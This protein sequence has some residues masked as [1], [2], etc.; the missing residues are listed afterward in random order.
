MT[1]PAR[2]YVGCVTNFDHGD[3]RLTIWRSDTGYFRL[4]EFGIFGA[5]LPLTYDP[6]FQAIAAEM[7]R[8]AGE[9]GAL[10]RREIEAER[11]V[12]RASSALGSIE[13]S[14]P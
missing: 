11:A 3:Q 6:L 13:V 12:K 2:P 10:K 7:H 14:E 9:A 1:E 4:M 5:T 8:L